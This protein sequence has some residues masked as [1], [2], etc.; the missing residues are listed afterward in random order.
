MV[1]LVGNNAFLQNEKTTYTLNEFLCEIK[2]TVESQF[3]GQT[4]WVHGELS[5]WKKHGRH[6]YGELIEYDDISNHCIA[7]IKLSLLSSLAKQ[8]LSK[9]HSLTNETIASGMK[10][11][12]LVTVNFHT[13]YGMS[14]NI[15]N[16]DP[17]F[18]LGDREA[19]KKKIYE[20]LVQR[21]I[22]DNNKKLPVPRDFSSIAV[23]SSETAAGLGDF[24][25]EAHLLQKNNLC[26]FEIYRPSMQGKACHIEVTN[27]FRN[28]FKSVK[29][30]QKDYDAIVLIRGGG[31][32]A[33]LDWFNNLEIA[34][35]ICYMQIPVFIGIGYESDSTVLDSLA[36][37]SFDTPSKV[38]HY[39]ANT[40][41]NN[42]KHAQMNFNNIKNLVHNLTT[43]N[44]SELIKQPQNITYFASLY[45]GSQ[46]KYTHDNYNHIYGHA[47]QQLKYH[48][49]RISTT[50]NATLGVARKNIGLFRIKL[51]TMTMLQRQLCFSFLDRHKKQLGEF[52][53]SLCRQLN[54]AVSLTKSK[55]ESSYKSVLSL[56]I[57]PTLKRG[58]VLTKSQGK[59]VT[60]AKDAKKNSE[61]TLIYHDGDV[62][63]EVKDDT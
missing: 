6:Y 59:Y 49:Q 63:T 30:S 24:F 41:I 23:I 4:Y 1:V 25:A 10:V 9:F 62:Q 46:K 40:I 57:E 11:L 27:Q 3:K 58:F 12:L 61:L 29:D 16:I 48:G 45:V 44:N 31:P 33:D 42:A 47:K 13:S 53:S 52:F 26:H 20:S 60:S 32:Q 19:R 36:N 56:A 54:V 35:A 2:K 22:V 51:N 55:I 37:C 14:L 34:N 38:I 43:K 15:I 28:I 7:K 5:D 8:I 18:T 39:I 17:R 21:G 50:L